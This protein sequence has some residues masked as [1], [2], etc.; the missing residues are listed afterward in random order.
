M[1][2]LDLEVFR[3]GDHGE[4]GCWDEATLDAMAADYS[5][6]IH[7]AP[8]TVDH[9][10][11]G[12]A[13]GWVEGLRRVG[14]VLM[15][16]LRGLDPAFADMIRRGAF[17]KRSVEIYRSLETTGRPYLR[18][19]SFLGACPPAV[20]GLADVVF[21]EGES[22]PV[23][24]DF[25]EAEQKAQ[26]D[27]GWIALRDRLMAEGQWLPTWEETGIERF[28]CELIGEEQRAW[29]AEFLE[30][31]PNAVPTGSLPSAAAINHR[32]RD[33]TLQPSPRAEVSEDSLALHRE[34]MA[35]SEAN[36]NVSYAEA[37]RAVARRG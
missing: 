3:A 22:E 19:V 13:L 26:P 31:L 18:A 29:F 34:V 30:S 21:A 24:I 17:K 23:V 10:Q 14:N 4:R 9:A 15:A 36:P 27:A 25:G 37:L 16:R 5:P 6:S 28:W 8:V 11:S 7:E 35:F 1:D 20:K 2:T 12:P 33:Q 32:F